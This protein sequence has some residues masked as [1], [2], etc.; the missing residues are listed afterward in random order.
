M[1]GNALFIS[2]GHRDMEPINWLDRLKLYLA[3]LRRQELVDI[4][5]DSGIRAGSEW[6]KEIETELKRA[7]SAILLVG[8]GFLA[9]EFIAAHELPL[10]LK[11]AK[12]RGTKIYPLVVGYCA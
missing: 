4:W 10:L 12:I 5:D 11:A 1:P 8:P 6:R 3:P 7:T 2:Y 9:S